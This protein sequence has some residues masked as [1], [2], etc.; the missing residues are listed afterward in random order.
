M[1]KGG[2]P[3][4]LFVCKLPLGH[5]LN[6]KQK[7]GERHEEAGTGVRRRAFDAHAILRTDY[8]ES[9]SHRLHIARRDGLG[10]EY[11][12][13]CGCAQRHCAESVLQCHH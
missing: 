13:H 3:R 4:H 2:T 11:Q 6:A 10:P 7:M 9:R 12:N 1:L 5:R 8:C